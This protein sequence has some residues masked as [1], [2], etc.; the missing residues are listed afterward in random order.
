M[1]LTLCRLAL[2]R[3]CGYWCVFSVDLSQNY[4]WSLTWVTHQVPPDGCCCDFFCSVKN[5]LKNQARGI[6]TG[7]KKVVWLQLGLTRMC[8]LRKHTYMGLWFLQ[9]DSLLEKWVME[10]NCRGQARIKLKAKAQS[11][12]ADTESALIQKLSY[13]SITL[14]SYCCFILQN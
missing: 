11:V 6:R 5:L 2:C 7:D 14:V 9:M 12:V 3:G 8:I 1:I 4:G 13:I 10:G